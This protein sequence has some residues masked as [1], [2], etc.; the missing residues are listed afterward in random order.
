MR[1]GFLLGSVLLCLCMFLVTT[2][3]SAGGQ[4]V[5]GKNELKTW[6]REKVAGGAGV[7]SGKFSFTRNDAEEGYV[8]KEIGW[9]TLLPGA[10]IGMHK[11][12]DNEDAYIII[13]GEGTFTDSN[14]K[15]TVVTGGDITIARPGD[16]HALENTGQVPLFFLDIVAKR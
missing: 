8:I 10:S 9:M 6:D 4:Q 1:K 12:A 3:A 2:A 13:F 16:S 5:Y 11:H 14:G 7:L 15:K